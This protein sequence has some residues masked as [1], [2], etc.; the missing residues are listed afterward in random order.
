MSTSAVQ[1]TQN[2]PASAFLSSLDPHIELFPPHLLTLQLYHQSLSPFHSP[3]AVQ[4]DVV[5]VPPKKTT[6]EISKEGGVIPK[7]DMYAVLNVCWSVKD[8]AV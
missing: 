8:V 5:L 6:P 3:R 2:A 7:N 4:A 1:A